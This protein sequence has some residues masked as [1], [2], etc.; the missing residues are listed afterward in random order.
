MEFFINSQ[1]IDITI[2]N[3]KTIGDVLKAFEEEFAA[4][5][6]TTIGIE[7]NEKNVDANDFDKICEQPLEDSTKINLSI[8]TMNEIKESF[9]AEAKECET[10]VEKIKNISVNLQSGK[11]KE[12]STAIIELADFI[13]RFC[14]TTKLAVLFPDNFK[15]ILES[16]IADASLS[17]FFQEFT[18]ILNDF[19][20][21]FK[22]NDTVLLGDL[23]EYE[24]SPRLESIA[25]AIKQI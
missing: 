6:A 4:N 25:K 21:A 22:T 9:E 3:E 13:N 23:S 8:I 11:D 17:D 20:E 15:N 7:L 14:R 1:K 2:E 19:E 10:L 24:I 16:G 18:P 12:A 5:N